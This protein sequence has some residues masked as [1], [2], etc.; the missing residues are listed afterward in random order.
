MLRREEMIA[1]AADDILA[2]TMGSLYSEHFSENIEAF[3]LSL[4]L[5]IDAAPAF[6]KA[7]LSFYF[8]LA[9]VLELP[10]SQVLSDIIIH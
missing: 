2:A 9:Q 1:A 5:Y 8:I 3:N 6:R 4:V 7:K 10:K